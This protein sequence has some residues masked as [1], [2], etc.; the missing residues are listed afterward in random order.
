MS[1][2]LGAEREGDVWVTKARNVMDGSTLNI[3]S[4]VLINAA[5]PWV[6]QHNALTGQKKKRPTS[7]STRKAFT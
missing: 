7:T 3:R 5:G 2:R 4:K 6:D 1:N